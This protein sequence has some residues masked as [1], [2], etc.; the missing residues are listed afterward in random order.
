MR[1]SW[2]GWLGA[3]AVVILVWPGMARAQSS[4]NSNLDKVLAQMDAA[5]A[6][7]HS[8]QARFSVGRV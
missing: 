6:K 1:K 5:S 2:C 4:S 8:A 3:V 7:F